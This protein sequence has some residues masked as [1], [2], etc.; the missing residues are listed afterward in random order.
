[1]RKVIM[2][3]MLILMFSFST[4]NMMKVLQTQVCEN[5]PDD[6]PEDYPIITNS[7]YSANS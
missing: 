1:M 7:I 3:I 6:P 5:N 4:V 2:C